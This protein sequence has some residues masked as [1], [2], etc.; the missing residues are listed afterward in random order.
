MQT[1][2][3]IAVNSLK[4]RNFTVMARKVILRLREHSHMRGQDQAARWCAA[5]AVS[6]PQFAAALEA[7]LWRETKDVCSE[8]QKSA[9][10]KLKKLGLDLGGGGHYPLLYFMVRYIK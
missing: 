3:N 5:Q 7:D 1:L 9:K 2:R 4:R 10:E 6:W 8:L